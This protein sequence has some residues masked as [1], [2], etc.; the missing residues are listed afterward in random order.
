MPMTDEIALL[1]SKTNAHAVD[2][3][4]VLSFHLLRLIAAF[5]VTSDNINI[6]PSMFPR[7]VDQKTLYKPEHQSPGAFDKE[8]H[9]SYIL[10]KSDTPKLQQL[11]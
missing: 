9:P 6:V 1:A 3:P 7:P 2:I 11:Q 4:R 10:S 5:Y 8:T